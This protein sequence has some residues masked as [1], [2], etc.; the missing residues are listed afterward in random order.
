L[1]A[2]D[3]WVANPPS[4]APGTL[5]GA[6]YVARFTLDADRPLQAV[7]DAAHVPEPW[8]AIYQGASALINTPRTAVRCLAWDGTGDFAID[9]WTQ[10]YGV[11][12][13]PL[14]HTIVDG[15]AGTLAFAPD[16][17]TA[18]KT[19]AL[20][21]AELAAIRAAMRAADLGAFTEVSGGAGEGSNLRTLQLTTAAGPCA[22]TFTN[23]FPAGLDPV[24]QAIVPARARLPK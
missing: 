7:F 14:T 21:A 13:G 1:A 12:P 2:I 18:V 17:Q 19:T 16:A 6:A 20:T 9:V 5:D 4:L 23:Q 11:A 8:L 22:R 10:D 24:F 3:A 15:K